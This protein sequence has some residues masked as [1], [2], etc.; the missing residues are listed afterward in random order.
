ML[1]ATNLFAVSFPE[2]AALRLD[3]PRGPVMASVEQVN[4]A[5]EDGS[6]RFK[7][8]IRPDQRPSRHPACGTFP[9]G[10]RCGSARREGR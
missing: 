5:R 8:S 7:R 6:Q 4:R 9:K 3:S 2:G 1:H 10:R